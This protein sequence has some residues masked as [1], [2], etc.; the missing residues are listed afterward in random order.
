MANGRI[1]V[2]FHSD[3]GEGAIDEE[4]NSTSEDGNEFITPN[5]SNKSVSKSAIGSLAIQYGKKAMQYGVS[6]IGDLTGNYQAQ[7]TI[8][9]AIEAAGTLIMMTQFPVGTIAGLVSTASNVANE[10]IR[11]NNANKDNA[12]LA[13]R[14]GN[15]A[16]N[17]SESR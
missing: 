12:L 6:V 2:Y 11:S 15:E 10:L 17:N 1:D 14:I 5:K 9:G 8:E 3:G 16:I 4:S 13:K 7:R